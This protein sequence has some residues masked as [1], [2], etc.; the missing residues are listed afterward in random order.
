MEINIISQSHQIKS[1]NKRQPQETHNH[2]MEN[3]S[4][5]NHE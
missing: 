5:K 1:S 2:N 4:G 3:L